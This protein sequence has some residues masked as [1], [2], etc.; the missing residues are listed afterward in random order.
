MDG[1]G[2]VQG[3]IHSASSES[4]P[5]ISPEP[6]ARDNDDDTARLT[7]GITTLDGVPLKTAEIMRREAPEHGSR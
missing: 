5:R 3:S 4:C 6:H 2:S 1:V 7:A